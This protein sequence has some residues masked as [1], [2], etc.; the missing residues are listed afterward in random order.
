MA[1][2]RTRA[3]V[4]YNE[5][6]SSISKNSF[7]YLLCRRNEVMF[8]WRIRVSKF[9]SIFEKFGHPMELIKFSELFL[10][11]ELVYIVHF[12]QIFLIFE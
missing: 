1:F 12:M 7:V 8:R 10:R 2:R 4:E 3:E 9:G 6:R 5:C 11:I